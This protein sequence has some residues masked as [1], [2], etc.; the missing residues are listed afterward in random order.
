[1]KKQ[2]LRIEKNSGIT[3]IAL[4]ITIIVLLI[5]AGV[6]IASLTGENGLLDRAKTA[7]ESADSSEINEQARMIMM[8]YN[9]DQLVDQ[10]KPGLTKQLS[11]RELE[12]IYPGKQVDVIDGEEEGTWQITVGERSTVVPASRERATI[13]FSGE[14]DEVTVGSAEKSLV[15]HYGKTVD[16]TFFSS[17]EGIDWKLFYDDDDYIFLIASDFVE[18]SKL[19]NELIRGTTLSRGAGFSTYNSTTDAYEGTIMESA[20]W[21]SGAASTAITNNPLTEKYLKWV[22]YE[23]WSTSTN[24]NIKAVAYMMDTSVWSSFAGGKGFAIGGPT[25]ELFIKSFNTKAST[26]FVEY[27]EISEANSDQGGYFYKYETMSYWSNYKI[28]TAKGYLNSSEPDYVKD[29]YEPRYDNSYKA[30]GTWLASPLS[31]FH[32][33][34]HSVQALGAQVYDGDTSVTSKGCGFRPVVVLKK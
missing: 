12:K 11:K 4:V 27:D 15:A 7:K 24:P 5:L 2:K 17:V 23:P 3:L 6:A 31:W 30:Y 10:N 1:M 18:H 22:Q 32:A 26:K 14:T 9:A 33:R 34:G 21:S 16:S 13:K 20:P 8:A 29:M 25:L 19:P 28:G